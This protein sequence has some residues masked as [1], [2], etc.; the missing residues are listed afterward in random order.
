MGQLVQIAQVN[1]ATGI[2]P[3]QDALKA[4]TEYS[5]MTTEL[6]DMAAMESVA[7]AKVNVLMGRNPNTPIQ[8]SE[9]FPAPP[10]NFDLDK[11]QARAIAE[12]PA[13]L[14]MQYKVDMA[15][16]G[17]DLAKK[18]KKPDFALE[19]KY[20]DRKP[21]EMGESED[22]WSIEVMTMLP[23]WGGKN[24][25]EVK[26][27]QA[28]LE[29]AQAS[30][31]A[32][33]NMTALDVQMALT[34]AQSA[35]RQIDLYQKNIIPQ[36]DQTYQASHKLLSLTELST[37]WMYADVYEKD[38]A[39]INVGQEVTVTI[40]SYPEE[41]FNGRIIFIS[42][43]VDDATRTVKVRVE[44]NNTNGKLKPNM[45]VSA[46]IKAPLGE[47]LVIPASALLDTGTRQ[48]V[49]VA[50]SEDTFV[51]RDITVGQEAEGFIQVLS[52]LQPNETVVTQATF[53]IDSQTK[54]GSFGGHAGHG[55]GGGSSAGNAPAAMPTPAQP[56][57]EAPANNPSGHSQHSGH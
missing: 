23:I 57:P 19:F 1:Y 13:L 28:G 33:K 21:G 48:V 40:P 37:V 54:L 25:A 4:Q 6:L 2:V 20:N 16:N 12:K 10:P 14:G 41:S 26:G 11:L 42:P 36:A 32:M 38:I 50:Q 30:Y 5:T 44:M 43:V 34:K 51:K 9:D 55:G 22:T 47:S 31:E 29:S 49:Y 18:K 17:V 27:A 35:W 8:V 39:S 46:V 52:G 56:A 24:R 53:L 45:F 15:K 7:K 3:L